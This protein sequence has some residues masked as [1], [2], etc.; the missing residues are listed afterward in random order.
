MAQDYKKTNFYLPK[1]HGISEFPD[2]L[3]NTDPVQYTERRRIVSSLYTT[4]AA[5][6]AEPHITACVKTLVNQLSVA[7][8]AN[9]PLDLSDWMWVAMST[10]GLVRQKLI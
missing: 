2:H 9:M 5:L 6:E 10:R 7:A 8:Y 4:S 1:R 3:T